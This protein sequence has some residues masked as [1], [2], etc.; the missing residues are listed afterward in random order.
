M[1]LAA[2]W[3]ELLG[4]EQAGRNDDFF[5]FGGRSLAANRLALRAARAL[6]VTVELRDIYA[7]PTPAALARRIRSRSAPAQDALPCLPPGQPAPL[8][9]MQRRL[10]V[11]DQ[12]GESGS[13]YH[14]C[15]LTKLTGSL[16]AD[17]LR[18]RGLCAQDLGR[19][20]RAGG[21]H[22][23]LSELRPG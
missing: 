9:P 17:A 3:A 22:L 7:A 13:A 2:L 11:I 12:L 19:R 8:S 6:G 10:W 21:A 1:K 18:A 4:R 14:I 15:G 16:D 23:P 20:L 5:D